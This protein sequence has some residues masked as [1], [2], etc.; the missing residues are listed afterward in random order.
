VLSHKSDAQRCAHRTPWLP[1]G[2]VGSVSCPL[3]DWGRW[4]PLWGSRD[5][6][7]RKA[8]NKAAEEAW[9]QGGPQSHFSSCKHH[10]FA[11]WGLVY[12]SGTPASFQALR[13]NVDAAQQE[14][15][16]LASL[17][18]NQQ[19]YGEPQQSTH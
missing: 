12:T 17:S 7:R 5:P 10:S 19:L 16:V 4:P 6:A 18:Q 3:K 9:P 2:T 1:L 15:R 8:Q 13:Y 11:Q 14:L